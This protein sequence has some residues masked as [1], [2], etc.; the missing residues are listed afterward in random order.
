MK[1]PAGQPVPVRSTSEVDEWVISLQ[2]HALSAA[3]RMSTLCEREICCEYLG[4]RKGPAHKAV[5]RK[6]PSDWQVPA[7]KTRNQVDVCFRWTT[8]D[9]E[10]VITEQRNNDAWLRGV[11]LP[12][13]LGVVAPVAPCTLWCD[14]ALAGLNDAAKNF[15]DRYGP[16]LLLECGMQVQCTYTVLQ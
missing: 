1:R 12:Q 14:R 8:K 11:F 6:H 9:L 10:P 5:Y 2:A 13:S 16:E 3:E 4:Q 15:V 7:V